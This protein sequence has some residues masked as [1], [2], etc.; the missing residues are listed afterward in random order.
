MPLAPLIAMRSQDVTSAVEYRTAGIAM[1]RGQ[2]AGASGRH[3]ESSQTDRHAQA[4][5]S[6]PRAGNVTNSDAAGANAAAATRPH[7][8]RIRDASATTHASAR[9]PSGISGAAAAMATCNA[10]AAPRISRDATPANVTGAGRS[11]RSR[12]R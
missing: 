5:S 1:A 12:E 4:M 3:T 9:Q 2:P 10:S 7:Q 6:T 8:G 11:P